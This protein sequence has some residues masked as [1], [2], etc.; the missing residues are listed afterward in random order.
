MSMSISFHP[1]YVMT[2]NPRLRIEMKSV[3]AK[4]SNWIEFEIYDGDKLQGEIVVYDADLVI[5]DA[6]LEDAA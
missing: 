5:K 3:V 6:N 4:N 2:R 1:T